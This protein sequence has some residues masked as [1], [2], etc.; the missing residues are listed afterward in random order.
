MFGD[1]ICVG[2]RNSARVTGSLG[3]GGGGALVRFKI[4]VVV[5]LKKKAE[6]LPSYFRGPNCFRRVLVSMLYSLPKIYLIGN[7]ST[8]KRARKRGPLNLVKLGFQKLRISNIYSE[9]PSSKSRA[10][11][12]RVSYTTWCSDFSSLLQ[13]LLGTK[14]LHLTKDQRAEIQL[15][16]KKNAELRFERFD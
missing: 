3:W 8:E 16:A 2:M 9:A 1:G 5:S 6:D 15:V 4:I 7:F 11:I 10:P 14:S 13:F 12:F